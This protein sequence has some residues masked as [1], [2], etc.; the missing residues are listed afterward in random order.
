MPG[1]VD[2]ERFTPGAAHRDG[3]VCLFYHGRVDRRKGVLDLLHALPM[4]AGAWH[5]TISGIDPDV[6]EVQVIAAD[7][8]LDDRVTFTGYADY[9]AVPEL[10]RAHHVFVSPN[11][12]EGFSNMIPEAMASGQA[13]LSFRSVGVANCIR[14][15]ENGVLVEPGDVPAIAAALRGLK[16][17][18]TDFDRRLE[19]GRGR[20]STNRQRVISRDVR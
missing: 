18:S 6:D 4:V 19:A 12:A 17:V 2:T 16:I 9:D 1:A 3:P 15:D 14:D 20:T 13:V 7:L 8:E 10:Y 11:Y 5:C